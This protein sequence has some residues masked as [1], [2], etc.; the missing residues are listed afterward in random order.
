M[1]HLIEYIFYEELGTHVIN[2]DKY[3]III[4]SLYTIGFPIVIQKKND[5]QN[6]V[7]LCF[8]ILSQ[9]EKRNWFISLLQRKF[10]FL[11]RENYRIAVFEH[12]PAVTEASR[13]YYEQNTTAASPK[14]LGIEFEVRIK[15]INKIEKWIKTKI[16]N[17]LYKRYRKDIEYVVNKI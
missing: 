9:G 8:Q 10:N 17:N 4:R 1:F 11:T 7:S 14:A 6:F 13:D 12:I 2:S 3:Y 15:A 16:K 5:W